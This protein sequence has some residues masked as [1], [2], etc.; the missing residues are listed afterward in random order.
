MQQDRRT[1]AARPLLVFGAAGQVGRELL[2]LAASRDLAAVGL[3]RHEVDITR[4]EEVEAAIQ[5]L[6]PSIVVNAAAYT[7]VDKAETH[8]AEAMAINGGGAAHLARAAHRQGVPLIHISTD[9]VFDGRKPSPYVEGDPIA[10][11]SVYGRSKAAGEEAVAAEIETHVILR[12]AWVYGFYGTNFLKT[13][14]RLGRERDHLRIVDDQ[15]GCPTATRDIAEAILA[16]ADNQMSP[17]AAR[18]IFHFAGPDDMSWYAFADMI[19]AAQDARTHR[20]P[21]LEAIGTADYPTAATRPMNSVLDSRLF[22]Q[23]F[24]YQP[25]SCR[26]RVG[27]VVNALIEAERSNG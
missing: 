7:A 2:A 17:G 3:T 16:I 13:M 10:P 20:R 26:Q 15:R 27:E 19:F 9:Y 11:L 22:Q 14:L 1:T 6:A 24:G 5:R 23:T 21:T 4:P 18:G 8:A 12:T 25:A